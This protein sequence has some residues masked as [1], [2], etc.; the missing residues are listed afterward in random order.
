MRPLSAAEQQNVRKA[1]ALLRLARAL[2]QSRRSIIQ[3]ISVRTRGGEV[4]LTLKSKRT[5]ADLEMWAVEKEASYFRA[6]LGRVL[7]ARL[8]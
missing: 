4:T 5:N 8:S 7:V 1:I 2:N 6:A 3:D